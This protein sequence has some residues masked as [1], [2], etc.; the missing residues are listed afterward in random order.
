[1][2]T[3]DGQTPSKSQHI[4]NTTNL[5]PPL[6]RLLKS[7]AETNN[8]A[9]PKKTLYSTLIEDNEATELDFETSFP[10]QQCDT[11]HSVLNSEDFGT[12]KFKDLESDKR[13][14]IMN[15]L[16]TARDLKIQ[17]MDN[18]TVLV[19]YLTTNRRHVTPNKSPKQPPKTKVV[20]RNSPRTIEWAMRLINDIY[21]LRYQVRGKVFVICNEK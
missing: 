19:T 9:I 14:Q 1:M 10:T 12:I 20:K 8:L 6:S 18:G 13:E 16:S 17:K 15:L 7:I 2:F 4:D 5:S 11:D 3:S 21:H